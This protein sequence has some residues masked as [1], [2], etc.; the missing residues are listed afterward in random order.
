MEKSESYV[1]FALKGDDFDPH[2]ITERIGIKPTSSFQKGDKGEYNPKLKFSCWK[3]STERG[4]EPIEID[5]LV[6]EIIDQLFDKI[7]L[8][9]ALKKELNLNSV[10]EIV[11]E[12]DT[13]PEKSTPALGHD[14]KTIEFLHRT[15]TI[16][17][18]DI[19]RYNSSE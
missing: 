18:V 15:R 1:Y 8:I 12:I 4:K 14:L 2:L 9:N 11:L 13:N 5:N 16:T 10:L 7:E 6:T 17:D 3:L 19:Y